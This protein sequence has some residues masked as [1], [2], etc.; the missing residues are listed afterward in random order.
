MCDNR[1]MIS[2]PLIVHGRYRKIAGD[3]CTPGTETYFF[4]IT[5]PCPIKPPRFIVIGYSPG[6]VKAGDPVTFTLTQFD[7]CYC[8]DC[9]KSIE[10]DSLVHLGFFI[11]MC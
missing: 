9:L 4:P 7:V 5:R 3:K 6:L 8:L 2:S 10:Y 1:V 11:I